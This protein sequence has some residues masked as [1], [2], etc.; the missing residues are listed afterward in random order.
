MKDLPTVLP[1]GISLAAVLPRADV[2]D[3]FLSPSDFML[4]L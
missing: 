2:R 3:A 4:I 1:D